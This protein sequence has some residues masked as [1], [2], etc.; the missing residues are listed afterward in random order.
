MRL[1]EQAMRAS[2][3]SGDELTK[4]FLLNN[5]GMNIFVQ[6]GKIILYM[7]P[8]AAFPSCTWGYLV[9]ALSMGIGLQIFIHAEEEILRHLF[10]QDY[11]DY[12]A[13]VD[14]LVPFM[15]P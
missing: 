11:A 4:N 1:C 7:L 12:M 14:R 3:H 8:G 9:A 10:G 2:T 13:R 5:K 6:G 15:K